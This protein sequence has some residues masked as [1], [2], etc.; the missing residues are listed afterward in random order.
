MSTTPLE[1]PVALFVFARPDTTR[2]VLAAVR[3]ARPRRLLVVADA[4]PAERPELD[5]KCAATRGVIAEIDWDCDVRTDYAERHIGLTRRVETGLDWVFEEVEEAIILEDDC[6]PDP[7]F[8]RFC[9]EALAHNRH[10]RMVTTVSGNNYGFAPPRA[11]P[12]YRYSRYPLTC[13]WATWRRA[14]QAHDP[15]MEEWPALRDS[16]WLETLFDD[17]HS[18]GYWSYYFERA[19]AG[20]GWDHA[21]TFTSWLTGALSVAP[22]VN[23]V[24]NLGFRA[25][26]T[27]SR[28]ESSPVARLPTRPMRFPLRH[29]TEV[30]SDA[31]GDRCLEEALFG[32]NRRRMFERLRRARG[33]QREVL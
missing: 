6:C 29:P 17:P 27:H 32:G 25:D 18:V 3:A 30:T 22:E 8:F 9:E 14:W 4:A 20:E 33:P 15:A 26:A 1:T 10:D 16:G 28:D 23:L 5:A 19:R 11:G 31:V 12:S 13:G 21:W 24:T 7:T 2:E